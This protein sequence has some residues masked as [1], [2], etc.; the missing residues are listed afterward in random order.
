MRS[1]R[2]QA[3]VADGKFL[4]LQLAWPAGNIMRE[5]ENPVVIYLS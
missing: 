3:A 5:R 4:V 2:A 1:P